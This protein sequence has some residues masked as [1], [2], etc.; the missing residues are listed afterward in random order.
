M[1][2]EIRQQ[3]SCKLPRSKLFKLRLLC[4][5]KKIGMS[6]F[7]EQCVDKFFEDN[8]EFVEYINAGESK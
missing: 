4:N 6:E 5:Y 1:E 2:N 8:K 7:F 3:A